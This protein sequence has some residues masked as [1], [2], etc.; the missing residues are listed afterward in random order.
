MPYRRDGLIEVYGDREMAHYEWRLLHAGVVVRDTKCA[1]YV[2][3][4]IAL[5]DALVFATRKA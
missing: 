3:A 1:G 2:N 5:R 4:E